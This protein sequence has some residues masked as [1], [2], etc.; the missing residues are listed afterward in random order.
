MVDQRVYKGS[1]NVVYDLGDA[2]LYFFRGRPPAVLA[3]RYPLTYL[4]GSTLGSIFIF[5]TPVVR[6]L[7]SGIAK[8][9]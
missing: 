8:K 3:S 1:K 9:P 7:R 6:G 2:V 4:A 5:F